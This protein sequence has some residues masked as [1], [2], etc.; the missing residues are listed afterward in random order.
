MVVGIQKL[1]NNKRSLK[2]IWILFFIF[3]LSS[4]TNMAD[5]K[6]NAVARV[7]DEYLYS[8][9]LNGIVPVDVSVNDS[10]AIVK[11]YINSWI[12]QK[13]ITR[14]AE[15]HLSSSQKNF[16][17]LL[18]NYKNSLI[19]YTYEKEFI[20]QKLD[21]LVTDEEIKQ[22]YDSNKTEFLLKEN[23]VKVW[24]VKMPVESKYK[25]VVKI[26][27]K[28][29]KENAKKILEDHCKKYASNF[30]LNDSNWL[31][32][33]DLLKE[34]PIKTYN[35]ED[36]LKFHRYIEMED[37]IF[38][39][40]VNIKDF[41]IKEST[42][43]LSFEKENVKKIVLNKRKMILIEEM[44]NNLFKEALKENNFEIYKY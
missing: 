12:K 28:S 27:Y 40:Y 19:Q 3:F 6:K 9:D 18:E 4:C 26:N 30:F 39:Y 7:F 32:F 41:K 8:S 42:S 13:L 25:D 38:S 20:N 35:Q 43:P 24:Y 33:N 16:D 36:Y 21:T 5:K 23:I 17:L 2:R 44:Q 37:S 31:Y 11:A 10:M 15:N 29:S 14:H 22:Y 1:L 34:I